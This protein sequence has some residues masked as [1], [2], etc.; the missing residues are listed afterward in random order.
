MLAPKFESQ[1]MAHGLSRKYYCDYRDVTNSTLDHLDRKVG[2][3]NNESAKVRWFI[4]IATIN[5]AR[6]CCIV[7]APFTRYTDNLKW[8]NLSFFSFLSYCSSPYS[9]PVKTFIH[10][11]Q[12][13][14][15]VQ[16]AL[17]LPVYYLIPSNHPYMCTL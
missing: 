14:T 13:S 7:I 5:S 15:A 9:P 16:S 2:E 10:Q 8:Q 12:H 1:V 3:K 17:E 6:C 4:P 11:G